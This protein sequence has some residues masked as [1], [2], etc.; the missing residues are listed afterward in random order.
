MI[1]PVL[2]FAV[3]AT[4][5][6]MGIRSRVHRKN[7]LGHQA[8]SIGLGVN[9]IGFI[10]AVVLPA[11][12]LTIWVHG[13]DGLNGSQNIQEAKVV[14]FTPATNNADKNVF[15]TEDGT[16]VKSSESD[17]KYLTS[18]KETTIRYGNINMSW[19]HWLPFGDWESDSVFVEYTPGS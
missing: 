3:V 1:G 18:D 8:E 2:L 14:S 19:G 12:T 7:G 16:V 9:V 10:S 4:L 11:I 17:T 6:W 15:V 5:V 13:Y